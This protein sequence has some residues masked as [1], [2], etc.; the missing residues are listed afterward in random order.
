MKPDRLCEII[1]SDHNITVILAVRFRLLQYFMI[2][3][4]IALQTP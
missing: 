1:S 4:Y 2:T 3:Y